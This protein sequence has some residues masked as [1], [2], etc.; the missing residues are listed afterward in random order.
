[1][2]LSFILMNVFTKPKQKNATTAK[3]MNKTFSL[4]KCIVSIS[5]AKSIFKS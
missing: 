1:M 2:V 3:P 4:V 5:K